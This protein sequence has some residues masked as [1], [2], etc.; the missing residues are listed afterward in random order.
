MND[1]T[2]VPATGEPKNG[3]SRP[4]SDLL[5]A[6]LAIGAMLLLVGG[7]L[8]ILHPFV[9]ALIWGT[10]IVVATW[11][12]LIRLQGHLGGHR[13]L[14]VLVM[15]MVQIVVIVIPVYVAVS[16]LADHATEIMVFVKGLPAYALPSPPHWI[17]EI[18]LIGGRV[19]H[20]WQLLSDAGPGGALAKIQP[21]MVD[22]ARWLL[23]RVSLLGVFVLH[24]VLMVIVCG[25]LYAKGEGAAQLVTQL[26]QHI[27]PH[28]GAEIIHL[29]GQSIRAIA[30][31]IVVTAVVQAS[32]AALGVWIAAIPY[33][34]VL[35]A[36]LLLACLVQIGPLLPLLGC[37]AWLYTHDA[38]VA[39]L[40]LLVWSIGVSMIDNFLRPILIRRAV[41]LPMIVILAGVLGGVLSIG[42]AGLFIGPVILAVTYHLLLAW[43]GLPEGSPIEGGGRQAVEAAQ[44]VDKVGRSQLKGRARS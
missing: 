40:L 4:P 13:R 21:Y 38:H 2:D 11:P 6:V 39:A 9:P 10:M 37:V 34:G 35:S 12:T 3:G 44:A 24:L 17:A 20:E 5:R 41:S 14:A 22:A 25:L 33:A 8:Y 28:Y 15:L 29:I 1:V 23:T 26:A 30:L 16:T 19:A 27:S 42:V 18:P 43:I 7:S 31:G 32:L 36:L